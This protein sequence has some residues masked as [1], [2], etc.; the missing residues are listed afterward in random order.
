MSDNRKVQ[1]GPAVVR[2][3]RQSI[4]KWKMNSEAKFPENADMGPT[5]CPL[6][7]MFNPEAAPVSPLL[8]VGCPVYEH[9]G[10]QYCE[11]TPYDRCHM[12]HSHWELEPKNRHLRRRYT[13]WAKK[14]VAFLESLLPSDEE[15]G[16]DTSNQQEE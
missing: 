10:K 14:E 6:C 12:A 1:F 8:C 2:A 15:Q 9:T 11:K 3:L 16:R 4:E 13:D 7:L 5:S